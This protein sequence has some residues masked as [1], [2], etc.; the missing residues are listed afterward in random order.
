MPSPFP[1]MDPYL[2]EPSLWP[3]F[4]ATMLVAIRA[5]L[6]ATL[7]PRSPPSTA[8]HWPDEAIQMR[9]RAGTGY[10]R[11]FRRDRSWVTLIELLSPWQKDDKQG[12]DVYQ[13]GRRQ[14]L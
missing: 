11:I 4:H 2:E 10:I 1:G 13:Y 6:H 9:E 14:F 8:R 3:D 5:A 7:P 12:S